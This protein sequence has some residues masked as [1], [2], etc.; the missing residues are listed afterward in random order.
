MAVLLTEYVFLLVS[1]S[2]K[3][4]GEEKEKKEGEEEE[5]EEEE[6]E[7]KFI[8]EWAVFV[9]IKGNGSLP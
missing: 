3:E 1:G 4:E 8:L 7:T 5:E 9:L 2:L 6:E